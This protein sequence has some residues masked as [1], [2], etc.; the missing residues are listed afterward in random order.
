LSI[1]HSGWKIFF[2]TSWGMFEHRFESLLQ[3]IADNSELIDKEAVALDILQAAEQRQREREHSMSREI[4]W[5]SEQLQS[6]LNWLETGE[7]DPE[8]KLEWLRSR[9]YEGTSQWITKAAKI[10]S[11]LQRL[12]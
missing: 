9:C 12:Q 6:V 3:N 2:A 8:L 7:S 11:W 5:K 10:R 4:Q 1:V